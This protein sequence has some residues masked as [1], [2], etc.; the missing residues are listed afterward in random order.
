MKTRRRRW[1]REETLA[2]WITVAVI[3]GLWWGASWLIRS[4]GPNASDAPAARSGPHV[5]GERGPD[6]TG[7]P[8]RDA[9]RAPDDRGAPDAARAPD[10]SRDASR[11]SLTS[12][13][14]RNHVVPVA[15]VEP[16]ELV[17]TFNDA[18]GGGSR[19]HDAI[20]IIAPRGTPVLASVE[21]RIVKL[22][23]S[24]AGGLTIYQFDEAEEFCYYYAHLDSYAPDLTEGQVVTRG[25]VIGFV[26]TT[27]NAPPDVPHL[28]FAITRLD[29]DKKWWE[30]EPL[31]PL[32]FLR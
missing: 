16:T 21:G 11:V 6:V 8:V 27:G 1:F 3:L 23:S 20:D 2:P 25:Q 19:R 26:G 9:S 29:T 7:A 17:S 5:P 31:D 32:P 24:A 13:A 10:V 12:P 4:G 18:R 22:F 15:G 30:G 28:H 14:G